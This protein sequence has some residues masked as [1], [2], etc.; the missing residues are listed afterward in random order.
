VI[1]EAADGEPRV[2]S[3]DGTDADRGIRTLTL[4]RPEVRNAFDSQ[5]YDA[6]A[7]ALDDAAADPDVSVVVLT[8]SGA[9]FSSGADLNAWRH[10]DMDQLRT[11]FRRV[12]GALARFPKPLLAAVQGPAVGFGATML[13]HADLV[14]AARSARFRFPFSAL[15]TVP[16]AG[17]S[18]AIVERLGRQA[19]F[20][21]LL[22]GPWV[23]AEEACE[24]GLV[25]KVADDTDLLAM[26]TEHARVLASYPSAVVQAGKGLLV[27][28]RAERVLAALD[29]EFLAGA[30]LGRSST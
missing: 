19:A 23:S 4:C 26:V 3:A 29:R 28:G 14:F 16:E 17:S 6:L 1:Q 21:L 13:A 24:S 15:D 2:L 25:W 8:A 20:W 30:A 5:G 22:A 12:V 11:A 7:A 18:V 10:G 9:V 27:E